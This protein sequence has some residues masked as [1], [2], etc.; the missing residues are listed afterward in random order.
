MLVDRSMLSSERLH[1]PADWGRGRS[2]QA[3]AGWSL[4]SLIRMLREGLRAPKEI[5]AP[6]ENQQSQL[7]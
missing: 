5:E 3:K 2:S 6:Q 7:T 1:P 4:R